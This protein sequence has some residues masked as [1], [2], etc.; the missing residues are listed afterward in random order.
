MRFS[1]AAHGLTGV[2]AGLLTALACD[3][4]QGP[5]ITLDVTPD[6]VQL[7]RNASLRLAVNALD[8][9]GHLVI[10]VAVSFLSAD[11]TIATVDSLGVVRSSTK[12]GRTIVHVMA[13]RALTDVPVTVTGTPSAVLITP[14]DTT[15]GSPATVQ[16]R[17]V[18]LDE[19]GDTIRGVPVTWHASDTT[20]AT[21]TQSGLATAKPTVGSTFVFAHYGFFAGG[22]IL[23]VA[24]P[25]IPTLITIAPQDTAIRVGESVQLRATLRDAFGDS[26]PGSISWTSLNPSLLSVS[27]AG[28][29]QSLGPT[30]AGNIRATADGDTLSATAGVA[31]LDTILSGRT[32]V[33]NRAYAAAI[34]AADVAYVGQTDLSLVLRANLPSHAFTDSTIVGSIPTEIAFNSTGTR[35]YVTN[36]SSWTISVINVATNT[37]IDAIPV[38]NRPFEVIVE[39]GDSILWTGKIDS[40]YG[41]RLATKAIIARFQIGDVGNGVAIARDTLLYVSTHSTGTIVEIN[42][43]TRA[44]GR[45]FTVG[46]IPQKLVVSP[47]GTELYIANESGYIQFWDLDT[48]LQIG[49]NLALPSAAYGLARRS[50]TG[51]LYATSAYYGGGYI[52]IVDPASRTLVYSTIVGGSTRHV[53]FTADGSMGLVPNEDGWVD[54]IK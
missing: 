49:S 43:R 36:Q 24:T 14:Q 33:R 45:T 34:S 27:T 32:K 2:L 26:V 19:I 38:G 41:I 51:M 22:A 25:G 31:V 42:L 1:R 18:V 8:G 4:G 17:A 21:I 35:A 28:L 29:V 39:P 9:E 13:A 23:R 50:T 3:N 30:G 37:V 11:T 46:G 40:L 53:V 47:D 5:G 15:I 52:Y 10:G 54:F 44:R 48:G 16:Y 12:T 20:V 6:S 7:L